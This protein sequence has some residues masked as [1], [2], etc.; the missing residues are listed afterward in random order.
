[1]SFGPQRFVDLRLGGMSG[2][3][4]RLSWRSHPHMG[5]GFQMKTKR[6]A[7]RLETALAH[8]RMLEPGRPVRRHDVGIYLASAALAAQV[9]VGTQARATDRIIPDERRV[10]RYVSLALDRVNAR[11]NPGREERLKWVYRARGLPLVVVAEYKTWRRVCD[12]EGA[13]SWVERSS[14][15]PQRTVINLSSAPMPLRERPNTRTPISTF[16]ASR[17]V[18]R[19]RACAGGWC[20]VAAGDAIGWA[21][22]SSVWGVSN[23]PFCGGMLTFQ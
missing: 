20:A 15:S 14:L 13:L 10:P 6:A 17:A 2:R 7:G 23:G 22:A 12:P 21:P 1:M 9:L 5:R 18:A 3:A 4:S 8:G 19:L 16:L 11:A